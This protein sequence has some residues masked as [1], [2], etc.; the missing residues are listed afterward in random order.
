MQETPGADLVI[1]EVQANRIEEHVTIRNRGQLHQP[2][3]GWALASLHGLE[4][5]CFPEG[6]VLAP[7]AQIRVV[8]GEG[9][10]AAPPRDLLWTHESVWS[11]RSDTALLFD[12]RGHE[13]GRFTYP[14]PRIR[15]ERVPKLKILIQDRDGYHLE[16]WD[17]LV[18]PG[19]D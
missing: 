5:F 10:R 15:E 18:P 4:V 9:A 17:A 16:D 14:R 2:L 7:G 19:R 12:H 11:N 8:S 3:N 6:T 1:T 13:V